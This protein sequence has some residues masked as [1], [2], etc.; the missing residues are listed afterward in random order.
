MARVDPGRAEVVIHQHMPMFHM[1][2][3]V[4]CAVLSPGTNKT[5]C[6][7]PCDVHAVKMRDRIGMGERLAAIEAQRCLEC[8][9]AKC[10]KGCPVLIDI[11]TFIRRVA[12]GDMAGAAEVLLNDNALPGISGRVCPQEKQCEAQCVRGKGCG[13]SVAI[14]HRPSINRTWAPGV[15]YLR[16]SRRRMMSKYRCGVTRFR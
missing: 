4:F 7:R 3:C 10:I 13:S 5:N 14:D 16:I 15:D 2:H 1:E 6:G 11:P 9:D 8:K 12:E